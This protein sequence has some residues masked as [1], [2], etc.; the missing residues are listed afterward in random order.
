MINFRKK[1][2]CTNTNEITI[3]VFARTNF[4]YINIRDILT[5]T[6]QLAQQLAL[7]IGNK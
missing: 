2:F 3:V 6:R 7:R 1:H 4:K 5:N